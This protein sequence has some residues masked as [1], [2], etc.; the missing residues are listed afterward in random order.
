MALTISL[1][2]EHWTD[3]QRQ[4]LTEV[5][6]G[7]PRQATEAMLDQLLHVCQR[8]G[9]DPWARQIYLRVQGGR[10]GARRERARLRSSHEI[11]AR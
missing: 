5:I 6:I 9:L 3:A 4:A 10:G 2:Q 8:T 11:I 1:G 7:D